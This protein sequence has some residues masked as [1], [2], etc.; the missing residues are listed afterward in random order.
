MPGPKGELILYNILGQPVIK[1]R[2]NGPGIYEF[3]TGLKDGLY[4]A[5][6]ISGD[7]KY[8]KKIFI[9]GQ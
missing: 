2:I 6:L 3:S 1:E 7:Q 5:T 8:A 4:I 9:R